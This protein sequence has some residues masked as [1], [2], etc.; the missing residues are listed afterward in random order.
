MR[1]AVL[2]TN[3]HRF[4]RSLVI[5]Q[6]IHMTKSRS[7]DK[8]AKIRVVLVSVTVQK[9]AKCRKSKNAK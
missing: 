8:N 2:N 7:L 4:R 6:N 9:I 1:N 3:F 5:R